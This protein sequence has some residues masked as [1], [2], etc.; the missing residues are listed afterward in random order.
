MILPNGT[1]R[2]LL[3]LTI[4]TH[5]YHT[6]THAAVS[7]GSPVF[8]F[9]CSICLIFQLAN[10]DK[11][12]CHTLETN[13][14]H[15]NSDGNGE[16]CLSPRAAISEQRITQCT[17]ISEKNRRVHKHT[18]THSLGTTF[19][20]LLTTHGELISQWQG[21]NPVAKTTRQRASEWGRKWDWSDSG[22][23]CSERF[24]TSQP[25]PAFSQVVLEEWVQKERWSSESAGSCVEENALSV[26]AITVPSFYADAVGVKKS[27]YSMLLELPLVHFELSRTGLRVPGPCSF[28]LMRQLDGILIKKR[29]RSD[30][31]LWCRREKPSRKRRCAGFPLNLPPIIARARRLEIFIVFG[32]RAL[33]S[34]AGKKTQLKHEGIYHM[35]WASD[36]RKIY[37]SPP[38]ISPMCVTWVSSQPAP[39]FEDLC[40]REWKNLAWATR[41]TPFFHCHFRKKKVSVKAAPYGLFCFVFFLN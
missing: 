27:A 2:H 11:V 14:N 7:Q 41:L 6:H 36:G 17:C 18:C 19:S 35:S 39:L 33:L 21:S 15:N 26:T 16:W 28:A 37:S 20:G 9:V 32:D 23:G 1:K 40:S 29:T 13:D 25:S 3:A 30:F 12:H 34:P 24:A 4:H 5:I 10:L 8:K 22:R 38:L 31:L